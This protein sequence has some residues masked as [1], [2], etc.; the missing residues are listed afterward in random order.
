[1]TDTPAS[2]PLGATVVPVPYEPPSPCTEEAARNPAQWMYERL[3]QYIKDFERHLDDDHEIAARL[4][5]FGQTLTFHI[6]DMGYFGPDLVTFFGKNEHGEPVQLVQH[7]SQLSVLLVALR[8]QEEVP[9][10]IGFVLD[11]KDGRGVPPGGA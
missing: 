4:V 5:S 3:K 8:K 10:R 11:R 7:V 6:E 2:P 1:M 9:R